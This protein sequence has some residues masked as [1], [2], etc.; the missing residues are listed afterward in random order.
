VYA[1]LTGDDLLVAARALTTPES[2]PEFHWGDGRGHAH[3]FTESPREK[4]VSDAV[5]RE[6]A[7]WPVVQRVMSSHLGSGA[8]VV[9]D[10]W[11]LRPATVAELGDDRVTSVWLH[12]DPGALWNRERSNTGWMEGSADPTRML[13]NFMHRSLWRNELVAG[14]ANERGLPVLYLTGGEPVDALVDRVVELIDG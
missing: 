1:S 2:H 3:Y 7:M 5:D 9:I 12:I 10:W 8:P 13:E 6:A 11:L 14:E 4:L